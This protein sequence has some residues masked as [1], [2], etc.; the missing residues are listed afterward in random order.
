DLAA[1]GADEVV[2]LVLDVGVDPVAAG[3]EVEQ[4]HL[5]HGRQVVDGLVHGLQGDRRHPD[6]GRLVE[7]LDRRMPVVAVQQPE[8]LLPLGGHPQAL[9][10]EQLAEL[11]DRLHDSR[12]LPTTVVRY[13]P[14]TSEGYLSALRRYRRV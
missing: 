9:P 3:S 2:V 10:P 12:R 11:V 13:L 14:E 5:A 4:D 8:D 1:V 7:R 6:P